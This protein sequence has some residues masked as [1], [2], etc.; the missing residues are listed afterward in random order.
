MVTV[1]LNPFLSPILT[2]GVYSN[3]FNIPP[4]LDHIV[5]LK[6]VLFGVKSDKK[7]KLSNY[8]KSP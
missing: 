7:S 2:N 4:W 3:L 8:I 6:P 1:T 5:T